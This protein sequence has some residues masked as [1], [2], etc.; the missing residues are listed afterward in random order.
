MTDRTCGNCKLAVFGAT[1]NYCMHDKHAVK[2]TDKCTNSQFEVY[3]KPTACAGGVLNCKPDEN[4]SPDYGKSCSVTGPIWWDPSD[5]STQLRKVAK[6][7]G[8]FCKTSPNPDAKRRASELSGILH[9]LDDQGIIRIYH[10]DYV[11]RQNRI[12]F[13]GAAYIYHG[14]NATPCANFTDQ[15]DAEIAANLLDWAIA[16]AA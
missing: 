13:T 11:V 3:V 5:E 7:I 1:G 9:M 15:H 12:D 8:A 2:S 14:S 10:L 16:S 6:Q 4:C